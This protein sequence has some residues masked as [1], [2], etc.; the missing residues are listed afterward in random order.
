MSAGTKVRRWG[1]VDHSA[2]LTG[3]DACRSAAARTRGATPR[4]NW[5]PTPPKVLTP[6]TKEE[7]ACCRAAALP[8][9]RLPIGFCSPGCLRRPIR[10]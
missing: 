9:G 8:D 1:C 4:E 6:P 7:A 2:Y 5:P 10:G 3:C